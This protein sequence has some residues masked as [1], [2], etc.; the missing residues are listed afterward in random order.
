MEEHREIGRDGSVLLDLV[1]L[2]AVRGRQVG[3]PGVEHARLQRL[4]DLGAR[5]R[6]RC[7][8]DRGERMIG[9]RIEAADLDALEVVERNERLLPR[10]EDRFARDVEP[11]DAVHAARLELGV[12]K[13]ARLR[14]RETLDLREI[15]HVVRDQRRA[16]LGDRRAPLEID[17]DRGLDVAARDLREILRRLRELL[18]AE[19]LDI[20][21]AVGARLHVG[22][23]AL[24]QLGQVMRRR[25]LMRHTHDDGLG[26]GDRRAEGEQREGE[27][28]TKR[29]GH[30]ISS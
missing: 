27:P 12:E 20:D 23:E 19:E 30:G 3:Q 8:A 21:A 4:V 11:G 24:Q 17:A 15:G 2:A 18:G 26:G 10:R 29:T 25:H 13:L 6:R 9:Q 7:G 14:R 16:H 1:V 22:G 5:H 28:G